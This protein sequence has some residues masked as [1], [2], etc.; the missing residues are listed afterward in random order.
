[1]PNVAATP[2]KEECRASTPLKQHFLFQLF[3]GKKGK[4]TN[5]TFQSKNNL[6][7]L[8]TCPQMATYMSMPRWSKGSSILPSRLNPT[9][10]PRS[11]GLLF[12]SIWFFHCWF[13]QA[14]LRALHGKTKAVP[15]KKA[16]ALAAT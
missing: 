2:A 4:G 10:I 15:S 8:S 11:S 3:S 13:L 6:V 1:M 16:C 9:H 12:K 14:R 7:R 5:M